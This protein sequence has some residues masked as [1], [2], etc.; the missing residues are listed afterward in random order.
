MLLFKKNQKHDEFLST[1]NFY[2][3][4]ML[5]SYKVGETLE[6]KEHS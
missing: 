1:K 2:G 5:I 4:E 6:I 3:E